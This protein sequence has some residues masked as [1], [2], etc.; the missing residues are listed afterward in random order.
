[1][2]TLDSVT[3]IVSAIGAG[4]AGIATYSTVKTWTKN[5]VRTV[6][7]KVQAA[8]RTET[9]ELSGSDLDE[10]RLAEIFRSVAKEVDE[11]GPG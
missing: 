11:H 8:N 10:A 9:F 2:S 3:Q 5:R 6:V 4:V 7:I 1:M